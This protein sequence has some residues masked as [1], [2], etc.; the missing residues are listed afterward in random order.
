VL[1]AGI[2]FLPGK[3]KPYLVRVGRGD[4]G[5]AFETYERAVV[6]AEEIRR[7]RALGLGAPRSKTAEK[8]LAQAIDDLLARKR[9]SGT[10]G[11]LTPAGVR[12]WEQKMIFWQESPFAKVPLRRLDVAAVEDA[13]LERARLHPTA[14]REELQKLKATLRYA[15]GRGCEFPLALLGIEPI[16]VRREPKGTALALDELDYL[17]RYGVEHQWRGLHLFG[18]VGLRVSELIGLLPE[19]VDLERG[20]LRLPAELCKERRAKTIPLFP[21]EVELFDEQLTLR[22]SGAERV[23]PRKGGTPWRREHYYHQVVVATR[24]RAATAWRRE[25]DTETTPFDTLAPHDFRRTAATLLRDAG[26]TREQAALRLGHSDDGQ[27]LDQ[28]YDRGDRAQRIRRAVAEVGS[29]RDALT[30][31]AGAGRKRRAREHALTSRPSRSRHL[32]AV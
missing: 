13:I 10:K 5:E 16:R 9:V 28:V 22:P 14:A 25:H 2:Y 32:Q 20:E 29:L 18:T 11:P 26:F 7:L 1:P 15:S 3:P 27:L 12:D 21:E 19:H 4:R 6:H 30:A 24:E 31:P 17:C 8:S 23:V